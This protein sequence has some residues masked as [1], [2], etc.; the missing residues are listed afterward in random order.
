MTDG[1]RINTVLFGDTEDSDSALE[2]VCPFVNIVV[3][4]SPAGLPD[5]LRN[6]IR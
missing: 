1:V 5:R 6:L 3:V 2:E 4:S